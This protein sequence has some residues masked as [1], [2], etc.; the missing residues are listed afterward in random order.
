MRRLQLIDDR[1]R[2]TSEIKSDCVGVIVDDCVREVRFA[3]D[4][5]CVV[6]S[7]VEGR[8]IR[9]RS[10]RRSR[11]GHWIARCCSN[12]HQSECRRDGD[13]HDEP[14]TTSVPVRMRRA[15]HNNTFLSRRRRTRRRRYLNGLRTTKTL[16]TFCTFV[17]PS[18][19]T[20]FAMVSKHH[21]P[22]ASARIL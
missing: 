12:V 9:R 18:P 17:K 14:R 16:E 15:G 7:Y 11:R 22:R 1:L 3:C 2:R 13:N 4:C 5:A 21:V 20:R 8:L 6:G 10:C 19:P